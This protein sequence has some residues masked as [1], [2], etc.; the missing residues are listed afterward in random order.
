MRRALLSLCLAFTLAGAGCS[1][2]YLRGTGPDAGKV[3]DLLLVASSAP[4]LAAYFQ[5]EL[6]YNRVKVV[7][8]RDKAK[9]VL[10]LSNENFENRTI[11]VDPTTG[12]VREIELTLSVT[13]S[14]R[15]PGGKL[16]VDSQKMSWVEDFVFDE[17]SALG[18]EAQEVSTKQELCKTAA[19][20]LML[21]LET[22]DYDKGE[23][24]QKPQTKPSRKKTAS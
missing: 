3:Q 20:A 13:A 8:S 16:I 2:W 17:I 24:A 5:S 6:F 11:S 23:T 10:E 14:V 4:Q 7:A 22:L 15:G 1:G 18:T 9:I 21:R 19:R 12:K